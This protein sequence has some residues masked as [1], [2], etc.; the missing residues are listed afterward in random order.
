MLNQ[1]MNGATLSR[2][3]PVNNVSIATQGLSSNFIQKSTSQPNAMISKILVIVHVAL[4]VPLR[5]LNVRT[6]S[7]LNFREQEAH[8]PKDNQPF[9]LIYSNN[10][11]FIF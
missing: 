9:M 5:I 10:V 4:S 11:F 3:K 2:V 8:T 6:S 1:E 7:I